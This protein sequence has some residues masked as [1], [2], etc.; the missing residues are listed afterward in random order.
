[1]TFDVFPAMSVA[2]LTPSGSRLVTSCRPVEI[3][4]RISSWGHR[5]RWRGGGVAPPRSGGNSTREVIERCARARGPPALGASRDLRH[6]A[7]RRSRS[8]STASLIAAPS[9][10]HAGSSVTSTASSCGAS[11]AASSNISP[12]Q[13]LPKPGSETRRDR[14]LTDDELRQGVEGKRPAR[15]LR[16]GSSAI[17]P[18]RRSPRRNQQAEMAEIVDGDIVLAGERTKTS[19]PRIIPLSTAAQ[20]IIKTLPRDGDFVFKAGLPDWSRAKARLDELVKIP[21]WRTHDLRRT[22]ATGLQKLGVAL[23]VTEAVLGHTAD[24]ALAS[25]ASIRGTTTPPRNAPRSRPGALTSWPW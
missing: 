14:V 18:D 1:M 8:R 6:Q 20:A 2:A 13:N 9:R 16:A 5:L 24:L 4:G 25:S 10:W 15:R 3:L 23:Q 21:A 17:D 7:A 12:M 11:G 22:T 19:E